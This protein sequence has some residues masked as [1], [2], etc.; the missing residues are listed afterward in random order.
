MFGVNKRTKKTKKKKKTKNKKKKK[1]KTKNKL[2]N[3]LVENEI[4]YRSYLFLSFR[5]YLYKQTFIHVRTHA[6]MI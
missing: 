3:K 4:T 6:L 5:S 1:K 2:L